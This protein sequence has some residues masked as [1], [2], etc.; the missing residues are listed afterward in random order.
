MSK[1]RKA[2]SIPCRYVYFIFFPCVV[3]G[4]IEENFH[5]FRALQRIRRVGGVKFYVFPSKQG[6]SFVLKMCQVV[7]QFL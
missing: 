3:V 7:C 6:H 4:V 5:V 1:G 2:L